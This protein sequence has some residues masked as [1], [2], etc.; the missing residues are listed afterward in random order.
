MGVSGFK[1][2]FFDRQDQ[3]VVE[4]VYRIADAAARN[5]LLVDLHGIYKPT[6]LRRTYPNVINYEGV[7]GLEQMKWTD[8]T[9]ADM[10]YND[11]VIPF[12]RMA[13]GPIDYTQGAMLN[14]NKANFRAIHQ[15]PMSQGTRAHQVATYVVFDSPI[16]MLCDSPTHYIREAE[17]TKYIASIPTQFD[18]TKILDGKVGEYIV[19]ARTKDGN[20]YVGG[21]TSWTPRNLELDLSFLGEGTLTAEIFADG[22]NAQKMASDYKITSQEVTGTGKLNIQMAPGGG[23]AVKFIRK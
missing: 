5:K 19:T 7:F 18:S 23:F 20:W 17:T 14:A 21:L 13:A 9:N 8:K 2:D 6:G 12:T 4:C 1:V 16:V 22:M 15:Q 3:E 10:P 11:V